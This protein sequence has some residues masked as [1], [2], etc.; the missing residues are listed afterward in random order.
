MTA[1]PYSPS[2]ASRQVA[3]FCLQLVLFAFV[4]LAGGCSGEPAKPA[5]KPVEEPIV[6]KLGGQPFTM[7]LASTNHNRQMGL[8][9]R[10]SLAPEAGMVF[11]FKDEENLTFWMKDTSIPLDIVYLDKLGKI[12][13]IKQMAPFDLGQTASDGPAK[14]AI[15]LNAG[16]AAKVGLKVGDTID[17][18]P[19]VRNPAE[20][21]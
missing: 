21:E 7:E 19:T 1:T 4:T 15:E 2:T 12:V 6:I 17:L 8:M 5:S 18:P 9:Y 16:T 11:V 20:L 10:K 3:S 13:S 14:Y